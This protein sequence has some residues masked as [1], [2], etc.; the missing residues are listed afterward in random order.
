MMGY[1][2]FRHI[3]NA[4]DPFFDIQPDDVKK[5][6]LVNI[7][8]QHV[9][10]QFKQV[11]QPIFLMH[12]NAVYLLKDK[13]DPEIQHLTVYVDNSTIAAELNARRE[14]IR[15]KYRELFNVIIGDFNIRISKGPHRFKY[16]FKQKQ[17]DL[18]K[19]LQ[20]QARPLTEKE[21][22]D[23]ETLIKDLPEGQLKESFRRAISA[24]KKHGML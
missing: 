18:G 4:M 24:E 7:R 12:T 6:R 15:L 10:R 14:L 13:E 19:K 2:N 23:I 8:I 3:K 22:Y 21:Q 11:V 20:N 16:P 17:D 1:E 5:Q 9:H